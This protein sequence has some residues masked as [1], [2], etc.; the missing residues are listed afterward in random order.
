MIFQESKAGCSDPVWIPL[1][2]KCSA[3]EIKLGQYFFNIPPGL[4]EYAIH[5][6][7]SEVS[8]HL[9]FSSVHIANPSSVIYSTAFSFTTSA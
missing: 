6:N 2:P 7:K 1:H 3:M 9:S 8:V 5:M 4:D